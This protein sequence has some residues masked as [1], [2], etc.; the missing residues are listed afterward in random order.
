MGDALATLPVDT[1]LPT[2]EE[3]QVLEMIAPTQ[4][5]ADAEHPVTDRSLPSHGASE[6]KALVVASVLFVIFTRD[7]VDDMIARACPSAN[8][9][10]YKLAIRTTLFS[11]I[12]FL[13]TYFP[14]F[15]R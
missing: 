5:D 9:W 12:Y 2:R 6:V 1:S 14:V 15:G 10:Y 4:P 13:L 7:F 11:A 8:T 3:Q